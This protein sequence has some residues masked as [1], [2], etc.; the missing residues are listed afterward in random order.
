MGERNRLWTWVAL[1]L[2]YA[3][4]VGTRRG[5]GEMVWMSAVEP[6]LE[7]GRRFGCGCGEWKGGRCGFPLSRF[8]TVRV[9]GITRYALLRSRT[10]GVGSCVRRIVN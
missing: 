9:S 7:R 3:S 5:V 10:S 2:E 1:R 4:V 6:R 8:V